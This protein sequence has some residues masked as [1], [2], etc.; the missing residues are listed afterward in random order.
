MTFRSTAAWNGAGTAGGD[1][2]ATNINDSANWAGGAINGDFRSVLSNATLRLVSDFTFTNGVDL[3]TETP[4]IIRHLVIE[5][6][7]KLTLGNSYLPGYNPIYG[8]NLFLASN[9]YCTVTL[10]RG[11]T[12]D[13]PSTRI[14]GG[15]STVFVDAKVTGAGGLTFNYT[16][17]PQ[18]YTVLR[19][20]TNSFTGGISGDGGTL[21]FTSIAN[22][23]VP[24]ALGAGTWLSVNNYT[25]VY[26]GPRNS[27][28]NR[29][30]TLQNAWSCYVRNDSAS[31]GLSFT[32][33]VSIAG[34]VHTGVNLG[35]ISAGES[36]ISG[37]IPNYDGITFW[38]RLEKMHSGTWRLTGKN[39]FTGWTNS[40]YNVAV[41]G[42]TLIAD[43]M[44]DAVG[45]GSNRVF[46]AGRT[47]YYSDGRLVVRG[48]AGA[49]NTT[50]QD[51]GT[52]TVGNNSF[53]VLNVD[54]NGGDGTTVA[55][56]EFYIPG[57]NAFFRMERSG[58]ATIS[59][60]NVIPADVGSVRNIN[61]LLMSCNG[62][63]ANLL[64]KDPDGRVGFAAQNEALGF[65]RHT[66]TL[67][68][69]ADNAEKTNHVALASDLTRT[70]GLNFSTLAIDAS[71]N[72]VTLD[73]GGYPFQ[74]DNTAVGRG[75]LV[76]G[77]NP[78]VIRNG[79]HGGQTT[80]Y[81]HN[82]GTGKLSWELVNNSGC[83]LVSAGPGLTEITQ[84]LSNSL[85]VIEGV[86]RLTAAKSYTEGT[87]LIYG[88][89]VLE[90]GADLDGGDSS[91]SFSRTLGT[92]TSQVYFYAGG[93]FSAY[94]ADRT[95]NL[96]GNGTSTLYWNSGG[97]LAEGKPFILSSPHANATVTVLNP[98]YLYY[99][100]REIRVQN[101]SAA[102]DAR[103]SGK[104]SGYSV[105]GLV[106]SGAGT[107][108][109]TGKQ[110]Y[111]GD[112]S[113]IGGGLRL[114]ADDVFAG[115]TNALVLSGATLDAGTSRNTFNT[116]ELLTNSVIEAGD[117]S[118]RLAFAD[119]SY[120]VWTGSLTINGK[121]AA[122]TL[123][124]GTDGKSLTAA[125]LATITNRDR[126]VS[127]DDQ[128]YLHQIPGGTMFF[129]K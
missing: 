116:L 79:T 107:L 32:G 47:V 80:T 127:L 2:A 66:G 64:V 28:S 29:D 48:K 19:N 109:L 36:L 44:N 129:L 97:F 3:S 42:G 10:S 20:D 39:T 31:G 25:I 34:Y 117:G 56:R 37:G 15:N 115:G 85:Y 88:N 126:P 86:T 84:A 14:F 57:E 93:G 1:P 120:K 26:I 92:G 83:T 105:A 62:Q 125:Q 75:L 77:N 94:G 106:K 91:T 61:G 22:K 121:L 12:L 78:V 67:A 33:S 35:G 5:G 18:P 54:G 9:V 96:G 114:G 70:A 71:E 122:T 111:R 58:V 101:G 23:G 52:N 50:W 81:L 98:I 7:N 108:E 45:A 46:V 8:R 69:T 103:L 68:L 128:G 40:A 53:N 104:I 87:I 74:T 27:A 124:F 13:V 102:I 6:T 76:N 110:D 49:G 30:L 82:Y 95:V 118:A 100:I 119:S 24:S 38:T 60:T 89:G 72:A 11:L 123:R 90:I 21:H 65:I 73:L 63:R 112:C 99:R 41:S 43:Y 51:L 59:A 17:G 16:G 4:A 113:V 55:L